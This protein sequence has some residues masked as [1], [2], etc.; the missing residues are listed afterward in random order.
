MQE[1]SSVTN[2]FAHRPRSTGMKVD[3]TCQTHARAACPHAPN[4][5]N[6]RAATHCLDFAG[7]PVWEAF[8]GDTLFSKGW[9]SF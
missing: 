3:P 1:P 2:H 6:E 4:L 5:D 8:V 7:W 9:K